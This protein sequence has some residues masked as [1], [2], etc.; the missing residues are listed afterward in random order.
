MPTF[1]VTST[2]GVTAP[3][4][5]LQSSEKTQECETATIKGPEGK[6]EEAR[7]KPRSKTTITVVPSA[8]DFST[9][10]LTSTKFNETNDDFPTSEVVGTLFD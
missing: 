10:T 5:F 3:T 8:A 7:Q 9:L 6:V 4:G 2:F 1:G